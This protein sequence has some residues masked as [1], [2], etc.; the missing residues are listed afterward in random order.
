ACFVPLG[1]DCHAHDMLHL[2]SRFARWLHT[3]WPAG[4]VERLPEVQADGRTRVPGV[5]I[6]GDLTGIPLLTFALDSGARAAR[7]VAAD[8]RR[9]RGAG[10]AHRSEDSGPLDLAILGAGVSGMSAAA[11]ARRL[12]LRFAVVEAAEP[13][14]TLV[15]F[16]VAKP[17]FTYPR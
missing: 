8:L 10:A 9:E 15:N 7:T 16:P 4:S 2:L 1:D 12:G 14:F 5:L 6:A 13:F 17:I 11:E 3:G